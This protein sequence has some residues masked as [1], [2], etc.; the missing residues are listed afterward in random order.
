MLAHRQRT[1]QAGRSTCA[2]HLFREK[3]FT[4]KDTKGTKV[5]TGTLAFAVLHPPGEALKQ[6]NSWIFFVPF[7]SFVVKMDR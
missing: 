2:V 3:R 4:T 6:S 7:V 1:G 5:K